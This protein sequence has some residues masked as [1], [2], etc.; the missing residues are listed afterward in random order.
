[1]AKTKK[2]F[3]G[4]SLPVAIGLAVV[5]LAVVLISLLAGPLGQSVVPNLHLPAWLSVHRP[6][7]KLPSD[8][9]FH[10]AGFAVTNTIIATWIT[11]LVLVLFALLATR[12]IKIVPG[13]L[14][15]FFEFVLGWLYDLCTGV[16]GEE[17]GRKF[18]PLVA[19]I[20]LFVICNA[21]LALLPGFGTILFHTGEGEVELIRAANTDVNTPLAIAFITFLAVGG[22]GLRTQG[23][24]YLGQFFNFKEFFHGIKLIFKRDFKGA[25]LGIFAGLINALAGLLEGVG[26]IIRI[27]SLTFRLF[28]NMTAGEILLLMIAFLVPMLVPTIFYGLELLVGFIQA[29]IFS[30]LT[31]IYL[32][33]ATTPHEGE[34]H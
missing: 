2:G 33:L 17:R 24:G 27:V 29:L 10:I 9:V 31:L 15:G 32:T 22:I 26:Q 1:M 19:T 18:F 28:G 13:R 8:A 11:M 23:I 14:Q 21:W 34:G 6:E 25:A 3:L 5:L 7:I 12:R 16:T 4:C 20:F 30:G